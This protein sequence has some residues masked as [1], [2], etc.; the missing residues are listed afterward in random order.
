[1]TPLF[2]SAELTF[3]FSYGPVC[4][5]NVLVPG[6]A[7]GDPVAL[8][9]PAEADTD[10]SAPAVAFSA[11]VTTAN[12]VTIRGYDLSGTTGWLAPATFGVMVFKR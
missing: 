12:Q 1:M 11:F 10:W 9:Q 8:A 3:D 2:A 7:A 5:C 6:A 4:E